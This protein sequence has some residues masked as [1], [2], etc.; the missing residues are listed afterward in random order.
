MSIFLTGSSGFVGSNF[1]KYFNNS[2][3]IRTYKRES[4]ISISEE[5][6]VHFAGKAHDLKKTANSK[7]FY[8]INTELTKNIFDSFLNSNAKTFI[9]LSSVKAIA[10]KVKGVLTEDYIAKPKTHY[11]KSKLLAEQYIL[12]K[13]TT[14]NKK[15]FILRPCMIHGPENKGNLNLLYKLISGKIPWIL[16]S[17]DNKRSY[18][19]IENLLFIIKELIENKKIESGIYNIADDEP[20]STNDVIVLIAKSLNR[21]PIIFNISKKLIF[22]LAKL[23]DVIKLPLNSEKLSKLTNSYVV[24]NKKILNQIGKPLPISSRNGI[25]KTFISFK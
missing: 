10:D 3:K 19:S 2:Y 13:K 7:E 8:E 4:N 12:S 20:L 23:G 11:G 21:K 18:C 9:M 17:F 24:S 16:G 14:V 5:I 1:I 15:V 6:V 25:L 22:F